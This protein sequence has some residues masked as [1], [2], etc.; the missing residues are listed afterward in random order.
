MKPF[1]I[2]S[3]QNGFLFV[4]SSQKTQKNLLVFVLKFFVPEMHRMQL[5]SNYIVGKRER[6]RVEE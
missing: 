1:D 6:Q 2:L 5:M 4:K 3:V